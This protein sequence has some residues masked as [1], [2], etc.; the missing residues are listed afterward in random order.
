MIKNYIFTGIILFLSN[1][2]YSQ[3]PDSLSS[4]KGTIKL[5]EVVISDSKN[6]QAASEIISGI[7]RQLRPTNSAQDLLRLVPGLFIAQHAGGGKAEQIFLRGFDSDHGTDFSVNID[8]MPVNMV[9]HAHGQGYADFHFV[10]P[11]TVDKL[12]VFKGTYNAAI[13]DFATSGA[14]EFSTKNSLEKSLVKLEAGQ[15]DTYRALVMLDLL[16]GK[17]LFT[18]NNPENF[19]IAGEYNFSNAYFEQKQ[20]FYRYNI[21]TKYSAQINSKNFLS[22]SGSTFNSGW[23]ASGQIPQRAVSDGAI[24]RFGS[25]DP[26][27]GGNTNRTNANLMLTTSLKNGAIL[28]NQAFYAY[29]Q[30]NLYSNFTFFLNDSVN[31]D[32]INQRENGRSVYGYKTT[33]E[34]N[35]KLGSKNLKTLIGLGTRIDAGVISLTHSVK[36][37]II[38][39]FSIGRLYQ[40][41]ASAYIDETLELTPKLSVN[42]GVRFDYFDFKFT[43]LKY[44]SLSGRKQV[45]KVSPKLNLY[46][47]LTSAV[48]LYV[49][50]GIGFHSN[51]ARSVVINATEHSLP[52][53]LGY[54][55]GS[56]FKIGKSIVVNAA[57]WG[58]DLQ[59]ELVYVGDEAVVEINGATRRLGADLS[60]RWQLTET[61]FLDGDINYSYGRFVNLPEGENRIPLAPTLTS[62][63]G[64]S[65][66]RAKGFNASLRYRYIDSRPANETN[67]VTALGYFL[68]DAVVNY[69][70]PKYQVGL[71]AENLLNTEWNQAQFDTESRLKGETQSVNEL[72]YT[73]GT[74]FFLKGSIALFF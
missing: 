73:P 59:N 32:Q 24:S 38:D 51:D 3:A 66:K 70:T 16:K 74:P 19:Y 40:Q 35:S 27:E 48:Q 41:N 22:F 39:T 57:L 71:T 9:S 72:H 10:I 11:E 61:L 52:T 58:L 20:H 69:T 26:T 44:D 36:R 65:Y 25:I 13:G 2:A 54:E 29:Y 62:T 50:G 46:Y 5:S 1:I 12:K 8:G 49:H 34:Q 14:G 55:A 21:F 56:T 17:H 43:N 63:G 18:K 33:Y 30:F 37:T 28:K 67:T 23:D 4:K 47:N 42:A 60:L 68:L 7:D 15:F 64:L 6:N 45:P 53:A 31:G